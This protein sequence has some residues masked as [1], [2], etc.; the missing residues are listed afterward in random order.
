MA[1][2]CS[3][4][5]QI[6]TA[7]KGQLEIHKTAKL[8]LTGLGVGGAQA[9]LLLVYTSLQIPSVKARLKAVTYGSPQ[10]RV[11]PSE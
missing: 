5:P 2:I 6:L 1:S 7:I 8:T 10:V 9:Q 3:D 4:A 11:E